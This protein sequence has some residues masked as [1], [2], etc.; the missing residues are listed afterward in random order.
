MKKVNWEKIVFVKEFIFTSCLRL[1]WMFCSKVL[2]FEMEVWILFSPHDS[3]WM[4]LFPN[5][6]WNIVDFV[7]IRVSYYCKFNAPVSHFPQIYLSCT[8]WKKKKFTLASHSQN[9]ELLM[10]IFRTLSIHIIFSCVFLLFSES[11]PV[12]PCLLWPWYFKRI[13][14]SYVIKFSI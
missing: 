8:K 6:T 11:S 5:S 10:S 13:L 3:F 14:D 12:F 7:F 1:Y 4:Q 2:F 9:L